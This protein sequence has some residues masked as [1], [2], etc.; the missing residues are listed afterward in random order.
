MLIVV[1]NKLVRLLT[2]IMRYYCR[3]SSYINWR[4]VVLTAMVNTSMEVVLLA[5]VEVNEAHRGITDSVFARL[6]N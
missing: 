5:M 1:D 6:N 3:R 2:T 4:Y